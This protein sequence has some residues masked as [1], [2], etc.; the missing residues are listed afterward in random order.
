MVANRQLR[1]IGLTP[2]EVGRSPGADAVKYNE[3]RVVR[4]LGYLKRRLIPGGAEERSVG[5]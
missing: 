5:Y 4:K 3:L 2:A 1:R